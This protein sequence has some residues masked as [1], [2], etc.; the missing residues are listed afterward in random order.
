[1][2]LQSIELS[3]DHHPILFQDKNLGKNNY[4]HVTTMNPAKVLMDSDWIPRQVVT[5]NTRKEERKGYQKHRV[6]FFNPKLPQVNGSHVEILLTNSYDAQSS[7]VLQ[8]GV[9]RFVCSNGIVVGDTYNKESIR[10]VGYSDQ[11]VYD[12]ISRLL[13]Q[14]ETILSAVDRFSSTVLSNREKNIFGQSILEMRLGEEENGWII[15]D[16]DRKSVV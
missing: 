9:F 2:E 8:L 12:S 16:E 10:H 1:M 4:L 15:D 14:T 6:R 13:P 7:F 5:I 11:K 3:Q